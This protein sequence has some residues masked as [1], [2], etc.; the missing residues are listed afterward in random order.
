MAGANALDA[1]GNV[2]DVTALERREVTLGSN[3]ESFIEI[4][5]GLTEG[6]TVVWENQVT[7]PFAAMMG[8]R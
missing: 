6:E 8:M 4:T 5:S 3:D 1:N 2:A 7:N